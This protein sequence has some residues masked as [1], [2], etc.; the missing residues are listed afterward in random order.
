MEKKITDQDI[1]HLIRFHNSLIPT[2]GHLMSPS[3]V[4]FTQQTITAL[5]AYE[6]LR[7]KVK[8]AAQEAIKA[9]VTP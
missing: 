9:E 1:K 4:T 6:Q 5:Y 7:L 3:T 2:A 8:L